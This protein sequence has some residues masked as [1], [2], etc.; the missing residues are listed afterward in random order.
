[1]NTRTHFAGYW[2]L[3]RFLT[4]PARYQYWTLNL[5][6][7]SGVLALG[8]VALGTKTW[9]IVLPLAIFAIWLFNAMIMLHGQLLAVASSRTLNLL[10]LTRRRALLIHFAMV[11]TLVCAIGGLLPYLANK[12]GSSTP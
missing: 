10:P 3:F 9:L 4:M 6:L 8:A 11:I 1:M 2:Q 7:I 5:G 12:T